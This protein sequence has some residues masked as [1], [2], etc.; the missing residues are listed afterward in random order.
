MSQRMFLATK[1][2]AFVVPT[3]LRMS[4]WSDVDVCLPN[5]MRVRQNFDS[6]GA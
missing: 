3:A 4:N 2:S 5:K 6:G 1:C